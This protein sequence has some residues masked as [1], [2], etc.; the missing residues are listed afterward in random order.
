MASDYVLIPTQLAPYPIR[1]LEYVMNRILSVQQS[2]EGKLSVLG[3]AVSMYNRTATKQV[4]EMLGEISKILDAHPLGSTVQLFPQSTW[5]PQRNM[6]A[7]VAGKG[8]PLI[9][10]EYDDML[11]PGEKE[12]AL[13]AFTCYLEL[14]RYVITQTSGVIN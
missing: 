14:A 3:V 10:A 6:V 1:A 5:I 2:R 12:A 9:E 4:D 11:S 7:N 8:Y 13:D